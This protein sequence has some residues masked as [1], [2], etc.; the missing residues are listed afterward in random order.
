MELI[1]REALRKVFLERGFYPVFVKAALNQAPV[2]DAVPVVRCKECKHW[3]PGKVMRGASL[4]DMQLSGV[5]PLMRFT[6]MENDF[7]CEGERERL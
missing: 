5:C 7:C 2:I 4:D 3:M 1:D 6:R